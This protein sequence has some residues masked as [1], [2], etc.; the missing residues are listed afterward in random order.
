VAAHD[1]DRRAATWRPP[2]AEDGARRGLSVRSQLRKSR[3]LAPISGTVIARHQTRG[4]HRGRERI[5]AGRSV[6][7][8]IEAEADEADSAALAVGADASIR[9][10][11][12]PGRSWKGHVE[13]V[14]NSVTLR[15]LKPQDPSRPT[16]TRVLAVKVAFDEATPLR[17]GTTV[18]LRIA[19]VLR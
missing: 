3:V 16:D 5:A 10:D 14:L 7:L 2:A 8:E 18:E 12:F 17:L 1:L 6:A 19:P 9:C 13:E 11:G 15:R 4:D